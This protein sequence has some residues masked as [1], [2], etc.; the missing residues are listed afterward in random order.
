MEVPLH[1][2]LDNTNIDSILLV[3]PDNSYEKLT[4]VKDSILNIEYK[5][6]LPQFNY[7]LIKQHS[8]NPVKK[9]D[10]ITNETGLSY[11]H[12][13]N[14]FNEFDREPLI[15]FMTSREGP[16]LAVG[17]INADGLDDVFIGSSNLKKL[18][19]SCRNQAGNF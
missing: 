17:D 4:G 12:E 7:D 3:W 16:A 9:T 6:G 19:C 18:L 11:L 2:G 10:D 13:E 5:Q 15:P 14:P 8:F 1:I